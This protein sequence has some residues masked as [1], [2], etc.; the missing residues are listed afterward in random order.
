MRTSDGE[1]SWPEA[2]SPGSRARSVCT[3]QGL[4]PRR[5]SRALAR[6]HPAIWPSASRT[7]SAPGLTRI[8]RLNGWPMHSPTD[9]SPA[10]SRAPAHGLGPMWI[11][12][13]SSQWTC[14]T[15]SLPVS[16]R[17]PFAAEIRPGPVPV[18]LGLLARAV[19]LRHEGLAP[20]QAHRALALADVVAH[21]RLGHRAARKLLQQ[22]PMQAPRR[23]PL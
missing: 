23:M 18:H 8:S 10:P 15:Y 2:R 9:A 7:A 3:C 5:V 11:A 16:R 21:R 22:P 1:P 13:P 17:T 4:R 20:H 6:A 19:A 12:T 14:T